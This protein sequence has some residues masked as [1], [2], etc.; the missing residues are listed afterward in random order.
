MPIHS[1]AIHQH[2]KPGQRRRHDVLA[3]GESIVLKTKPVW[4]F[5]QKKP[6][7]KPLPVF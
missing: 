6:E 5:D 2:K 3:Q 4:W 7:S 1:Q